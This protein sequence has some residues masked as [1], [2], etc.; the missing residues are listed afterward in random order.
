M[1]RGTNARGLKGGAADERAYATIFSST[2][3]KSIVFAGA[4]A[5]ATFSKEGIRVCTRGPVR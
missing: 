2:L 1:Q 4:N 5:G 3:V